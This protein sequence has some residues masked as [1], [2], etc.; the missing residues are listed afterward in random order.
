MLTGRVVDIAGTGRLSAD[1]NQYVY[2]GKLNQK[3]RMNEVG[4]FAQ[5]SWR[6]RPNIT[7]SY[8]ARWEV[9]LPFHR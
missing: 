1:T 9:Q 4:L 5:D 6:I 7:L 2:N 3:S 8:G